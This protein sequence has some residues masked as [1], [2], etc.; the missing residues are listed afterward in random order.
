MFAPLNVNIEYIPSS[1]HHVKAQWVSLCSLLLSKQ[2][3][4]TLLCVSW[5]ENVMRTT[6][7]FLFPMMVY[8]HLPLIFHFFGILL[9][10]ESQT[11]SA[12]IDYEFFHYHVTFR[13]DSIKKR[14]KCVV[15]CSDRMTNAIIFT[16][17]RLHCITFRM[18]LK[19]RCSSYCMWC[20]FRFR[21]VDASH[22]A[23]H[24]KQD[25]KTFSIYKYL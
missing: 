25:V 5:L 8:H 9:R 22:T 12:A 17:F 13:S 7:F 14:R 1:N 4:F 24:I 16:G 6:H 19:F 23:T 10:T 11:N 21:A 20:D 2:M 3:C 15:Q 18:R